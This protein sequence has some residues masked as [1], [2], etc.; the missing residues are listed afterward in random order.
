MMTARLD[1]ARAVAA[2]LGRLDEAGVRRL[3]EDADQTGIGIG[4][5]TKTVRIGATTVFVK[6]LPVTDIEEADPRAT[7]CQLPLPSFPTTE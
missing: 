4:G 1:D 6:Q 7:K 5:T 3:V 2:V